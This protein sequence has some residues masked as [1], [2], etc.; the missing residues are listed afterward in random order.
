MSCAPARGRRGL[1]TWEA[2]GRTWTWEARPWCWPARS[3]PW[4]PLAGWAFPWA[5]EFARREADL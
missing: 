2:Q 5:R 4:S 3:P 1:W